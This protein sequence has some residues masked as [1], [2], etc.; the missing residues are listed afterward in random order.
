MLRLL[1]DLLQGD[2]VSVQVVGHSTTARDAIAEIRALAPDVAIVDIALENGNGFDVLEAL[3]ED[4][5]S[6]PV[7][8][9][10]SNFASQRY[11][12]E[13]KRRGANY[14]FDKSS[15]ILRLVETI[16]VMCRP[17]TRRALPE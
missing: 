5:D 6:R 4:G 16:S 7:I 10:L 1:R 9:M 14:F 8:I 15:E 3:I 13:A 11:R 17:V 2:E 12:E